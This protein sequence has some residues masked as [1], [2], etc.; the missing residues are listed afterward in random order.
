MSELSSFD[1]KI[2]R[3]IKSFT[4]LLETIV[5][6]DIPALLDDRDQDPFDSFWVK[7][8]RELNEYKNKF[9][10]KEIEEISLVIDDLRKK[11]YLDVI[12]KSYSSDL[13]AYLSDD[14][15]L[16]SFSLIL[17]FNSSFINLM[18]NSYYS[19][20]IPDNSILAKK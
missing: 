20:K 11:T 4:D 8:D 9:E 7:T 15:E 16:L 2:S 13:A 6:E 10:S 18:V 3:L 14:I 12:K 1:D 17:G 19:G 5:E